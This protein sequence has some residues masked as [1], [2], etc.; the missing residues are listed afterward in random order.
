MIAAILIL[1]NVFPTVSGV[2]LLLGVAL[3]P[4]SM[5]YLL[6]TNLLVGVGRIAAFNLVEGMAN[7]VVLLLIA[8]A[9][10]FSLGIAGF[11]AAGLIGWVLAA[12]AVLIALAPGPRGSLAFDQ[13]AFA[14]GFRYAA[15]AFLI[16]LLGY[17][18][19]RGNV[20][21][22]QAAAGPAEVGYYS[23][24]AQIADV[25]VIF[26]SSVGVVLF[27]DLVRN[28]TR[29]W[30]SMLGSLTVVTAIVGA[31]CVVAALVAAP[32]V[33][34][35]Y[36]RAFAPAVPVLLVMLPGVVFVSATTIVSQ[37]LGA[38]GLPRLL[39]AVWAAALVVLV[40]LNVILAPVL[41]AP[42]A[43]AGLS[44]TYFI[45]FVMVCALAWRH[46]N[47]AT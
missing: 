37:F 24:A 20:F 33:A 1:L 7:L 31:A 5:F 25:L 23:I 35:L 39:I 8:V 27:P 16:T 19:L 9:A 15:K 13:A 12:G 26:P 18:V 10:A 28:A 41:G 34:A 38:V 17:L 14:A 32:F 22:L 36:G 47:V 45:L 6:G 43:A 11:L 2:L 30:R 3:A 29:R 44:A 42:G 4:P 40:T 21:L 46:R